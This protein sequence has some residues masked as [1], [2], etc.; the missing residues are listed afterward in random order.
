[1]IGHSFTE[2]VRKCL[3]GA[4]EEA[5]AL[6]HEYVGTEHLLLGIMRV[7][8]STAMEMLRGLSV[9]PQAMRQGLLSAVKKG[10]F[11]Q[12]GPDLPY[13]SRAKKV[14]ELS[15]SEAREMGHGYLDDKHLILG[16]MREE[17]GIAAQ[18]LSE[19]GLTHDALRKELARLYASGGSAE[20]FSDPSRRAP[21]DPVA[22]TRPEIDPALPDA[23]LTIVH[24]SGPRFSRLGLALVFAGGVV[25]GWLIHLL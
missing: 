1:M 9:D 4:R 21:T 23:T 7:P 18:I 22:L 13:T 8:E 15:M 10:S 16:L 5:R 17:K 11:T 14:L 6:Q 25:V 20:P 24:S 12:S 2:S 19:G 3:A